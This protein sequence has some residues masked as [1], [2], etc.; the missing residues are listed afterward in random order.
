[1]RKK[2]NER[3]PGENLN[4]KLI[5]KCV[6]IQI[7]SSL[8]EAHITALSFSRA[9]TIFYISISE[10]RNEKKGLHRE[11]EERGQSRDAFL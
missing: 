6:S 2:K 7:G 10:V 8:I 3:P 11:I 1:M 4:I 5:H 9:I